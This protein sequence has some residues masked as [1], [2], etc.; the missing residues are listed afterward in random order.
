MARKLAGKSGV[1]LAKAEGFGEPP[2]EQRQTEE[3]YDAA[4]RVM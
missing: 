3:D 1:N 2:Q 4:D